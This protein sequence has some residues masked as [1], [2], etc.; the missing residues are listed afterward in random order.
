MTIKVFAQD[1]AKVHAFCLPETSV[2][3]ISTLKLNVEENLFQRIES[4][5]KESKIAMFQ[6]IRNFELFV[7]IAKP[8]KIENCVI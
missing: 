1:E 5:R 2:L 8:G 4:S 3:D 7:R 6:K